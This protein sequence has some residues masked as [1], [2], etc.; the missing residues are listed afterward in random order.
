MVRAAVRVVLPWSTW[1][2]VPM[3]TWG[4]FRSNFPLAA[5]TVRARR[6]RK[7]PAGEVEGLRKRV[8]QLEMKEEEER[9]SLV[10]F[11][12]RVPLE[13]KVVEEDEEGEGEEYG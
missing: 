3:L 12:R 4:F 1:P 10:G 7:A 2:M 8:E 6:V 5:R 9:M 13:S 11:M